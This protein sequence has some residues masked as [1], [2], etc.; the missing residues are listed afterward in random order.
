MQVLSPDDGSIRA[1]TCSVRNNKNIICIDLYYFQIVLRDGANLILIKGISVYCILSMW[2][3]IMTYKLIA[4]SSLTD[5]NT[6]S[7]DVALP[8]YYSHNYEYLLLIIPTFS[9]YCFARCGLYYLSSVGAWNS[10]WQACEECVILLKCETT[11]WKPREI[12]ES[13]SFRSDVDKWW[14]TAARHVKSCMTIDHGE[15]IGPV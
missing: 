10:M 1:E 3:V 8:L 6:M 14:T 12:C 9:L 15:L 4:E 5:T 13:K 11:Y 2:P 7:P